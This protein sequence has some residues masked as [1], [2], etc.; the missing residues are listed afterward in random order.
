LNLNFASLI[1][2]DPPRITALHVEYY[3]E[4]PQGHQDLVDNKWQQYCLTTF[5]GPDDIRLM[6]PQEF[7][8]NILGVT[9]QDGP[10][11]LLCPDFNLLSAKTDSTTIKAEISSKIIKLATPSILDHLFNQLCPGYSKELHAALD[12]IQQTYKDTSGNTI[13]MLASNLFTQN[14][15]ASRP[16]INQEELPISIC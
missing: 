10:I 6:P 15:A 7:S 14:L 16:S 4:L 13:F 1:T 8:R 2:L 9:L 12:H 11:D 5:L 3:V